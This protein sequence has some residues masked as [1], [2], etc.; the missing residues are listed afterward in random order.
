M[1]S[2]PRIEAIP[3]V[4]VRNSALLVKVT[5]G[6]P[7]PSCVT[8]T[9][10]EALL[11]PTAKPVGQPSA[12]VAPVLYVA[13]FNACALP[14][15][16]KPTR[17]VPLTGSFSNLREKASMAT[18]PQ[19]LATVV[20]QRPNCWRCSTPLL[21]YA[22]PSWYIRTTDVRDRMLELN[23]QV[24]WHPDHVKHGRFGR[25]LEGNVDWAIS[26][27]RYWGTPLPFWR[28]DDC[29]TVTAIGS[30]EMLRDRAV[31]K[32]PVSRGASCFP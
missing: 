8:F 11:P 25:W 5:Q 28:C 10:V 6:L 27:E 24:G 26:R 31:D 20:D 9:A 18:E 32:V 2:L 14:P 7:V 1:T 15:G 21:Y 19:A 3:T 17:E 4:S 16:S 30:F 12:S 13:Q 29:E 22:K 23:E